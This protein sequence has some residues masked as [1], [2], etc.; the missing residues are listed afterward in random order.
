MLIVF[1]IFLSAINFYFLVKI[2]SE[3]PYQKDIQDFQTQ[4]ERLMVEFNRITTRNID[5][6]DSR[7][8]ELNHKIRQSQKTEALLKELFEEAQKIEHLSSIKPSLVSTNTTDNTIDTIDDKFSLVSANTSND[9][10][11]DNIVEVE[12]SENQRSWADGQLSDSLFEG[13]SVN[14]IKKHRKKVKN[15]QELLKKYIQ[16]NKTKE[17]LLEM[18]Y[19]I[20]EINL[21]SLL[22]KNT[23]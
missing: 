19:N 18:G 1:C 14:K 4:T 22:E 15:S 2:L 13:V 17:E 8:E 7:I 20:N 3:K 11:A 9:N 10:I 12:K 23:K 21:V 6:L 16:E 5:L